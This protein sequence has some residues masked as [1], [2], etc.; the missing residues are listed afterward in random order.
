MR[1]SRPRTGCAIA[2][3]DQSC[4]KLHFKVVKPHRCGVLGRCSSAQV[5]RSELHVT[6]Q[7]DEVA[8]IVSDG[9]GGAILRCV[10]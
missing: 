6:P 7:R 2:V 8:A 1:L 10:Q 3:V 5:L 9:V 4:F